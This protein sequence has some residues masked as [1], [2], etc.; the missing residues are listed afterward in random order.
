VDLKLF[1]FSGSFRAVAENFRQKDWGFARD[2]ERKPRMNLTI[3]LPQ[4]AQ[5][6]AGWWDVA[7]KR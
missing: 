1:D 5:T 3:L 2:G 7:A 4:D 6:I